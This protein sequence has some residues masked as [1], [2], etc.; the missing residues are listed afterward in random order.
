MD[1]LEG[2]KIKIRDALSKRLATLTLRR[3]ALVK[4]RTEIDAKLSTLGKEPKK[5]ESATKKTEGTHDADHH[6]MTMKRL[7]ESGKSQGKLMAGIEE[8][9]KKLDDQD[10]KVEAVAKKEEE[11]S[12]K[13]TKQAPKNAENDNEDERDEQEKDGDEKKDGRRK[14]MEKKRR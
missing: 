2:E 7:G 8:I 5:T 14:M 9:K 11:V 1:E 12:E 6:E 3:A 10:Q 13:T 4:R